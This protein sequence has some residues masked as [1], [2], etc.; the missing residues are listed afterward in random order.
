MGTLRTAAACAFAVTVTCGQALAQLPV[1]MNWE[2][3]AQDPARVQ[4][5]RNGVAVMKSRDTADPTG[6]LY[7]TS[8]QYWGAMHG[9][10]GSTSVFGT[11]EKA[12]AKFKASG[13][14]QSLLPFF[15]GINNMTPPDAIASQ[16]WGQCQH[17]TDWFFAWHR[18]YLYYFEQVLQSAANDPALRLPYW[19][20]TNTS[21]LAMPEAYTSPTYVNAGQTVPNPLYEERRY[22]GWS[23]PTTNSLDPAETDIDDPLKDTTFFDVSVQGDGFQNGIESNV[24]GNVHCS[25]MDCPVPD[26]GAV[27][28]SS[29]DPVFWAHHANIDRMW[30]CWTNLGNTNPTDS[31]YLQKKFSYIDPSGNLVTNSIADLS[32]GTITLGYVYQQTSD[33]S[34]GTTATLAVAP[35]PQAMSE[36][37]LKTARKALAKPVILGSAKSHVIN[38]AVT[39]K[40]LPI[41]GGSAL[42]TPRG[43][44]FRANDALPVRTDLVLRGIRFDAHPGTKFNVFLE[45]RDDPSR[46][47]RVGTLNFFDSAGSGEEGHEGHGGAASLDRSFD[48]TD[49]LRQIAGTQSELKEVDV[50]FEAA[51]GRLGANTK[52]TFSPKSKLTV[53][54]IELRVSARP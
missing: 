47:A 15:S 9:Y 19:D 31:S 21:Y 4:S 46:R 43:L 50:V 20:Y 28:Y 52:V 7:R 1:R 53:G 45:R 40:R 41:A 23:T 37:A 5:L 2:T 51:A 3:F 16:V 27:G 49:E 6:A 13:G 11:I 38:A 22:P 24:H 18:L 29:N 33:C 34:R 39:R 14:D 44:A 25:V 12:I 17:G 48:V 36:E 8:W 30:D 26:M 42:V 35:A 32:T 54:E 10:F